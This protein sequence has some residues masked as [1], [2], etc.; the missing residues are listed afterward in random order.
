VQGPPRLH[1][2]RH[3]DRSEVDA[4]PGAA[5]VRARAAD[6]GYAAQL[7][8]YHDGAVQNRLIDGSQRPYII[9]PQKSEP[10]DV[11]VFQLK[12]E[13]LEAGRAIYRALLQ[14]LVECTEANYWPGV[15]PELQELGLPRVGNGR[16]ALHRRIRRGGFLMDSHD[17]ARRDHRAHVGRAR[18]PEP[19]GRDRPGDPPAESQPRDAAQLLEV[20]REYEANEARKAYA[21][22][23]VNLKR[24]LPTVIARDKTVDFTGSSGKR[25]TYT[26]ASLAGVMD[27]VTR[28]AHAARLLADVA[29]VDGKDKA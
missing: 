4:R 2:A 1:P 26:H 15:A 5:Q 17:K 25:T 21:M 7:A 16:A 10:Y 29:P 3:A 8:F 19:G 22:A 27:A 24:D 12:P 13:T 9:A 20:Q 18:Q 23:L 11:V 6:Y 14:R 28:A